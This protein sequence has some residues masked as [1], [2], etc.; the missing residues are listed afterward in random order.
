M[1]TSG[2]YRFARHGLVLYSILYSIL[3]E[4]AETYP[5]SN[6]K[7]IAS[8]CLRAAYIGGLA[9]LGLQKKIL[10]VNSVIGFGNL[11]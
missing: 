1:E 7:Y 4:A 10:T 2:S 5:I 6:T 8:I 11:S 9:V 3:L